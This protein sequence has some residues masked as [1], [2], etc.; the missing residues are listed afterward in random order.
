MWNTISY[1]SQFLP[2]CKFQN[3]DTLIETKSQR[4]N[5]KSNYGNC[6]R[7]ITSFSKSQQCAWGILLSKELGD[8]LKNTG[9]TFIGKSPPVTYFIFQFDLILV[10]RTICSRIIISSSR[11]YLLVFLR[12]RDKISV[13]GFHLLLCKF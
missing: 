3:N 10:S 5:G 6:I 7:N 8:I 11:F 2:S 9:K 13:F 12:Y 4:K 1:F